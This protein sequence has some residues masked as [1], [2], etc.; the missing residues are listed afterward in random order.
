MK[1]QQAGL[2]NLTGRMIHMSFKMLMWKRGKVTLWEADSWHYVAEVNF[3]KSND[4]QEWW[5][6]A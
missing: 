2:I 5:C 3:L 1:K 4:E 6:S